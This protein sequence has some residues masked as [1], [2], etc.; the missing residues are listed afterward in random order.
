MKNELFNELLKSMHEMDRIVH[1]ELAPGRVIRFTKPEVKRIRMNTGLR[2]KQFAALIGVS[3]RTLENWEQGRRMRADPARALLK[4]LHAD[5]E[6]AL[7]ALHGQA[8]VA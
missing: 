3:K 6:H 7:R 1:G 4:I 8:D 2:K 5:P